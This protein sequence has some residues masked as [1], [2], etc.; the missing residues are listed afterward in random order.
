[1]RQRTF[2]ILFMIL[3][4]DGKTSTGNM[5]KDFSKINGIKKG[6]KQYYEVREIRDSTLKPGSGWW[7]C[8]N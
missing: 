7:V 1:M 2:N 3:S 8:G 4:I 6:L 5:D